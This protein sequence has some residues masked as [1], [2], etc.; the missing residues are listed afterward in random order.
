MTEPTSAHAQLI[1][2]PPVLYL[3]TLF[4]ALLIDAWQPWRWAQPMALRLLLTGTGL[5]LGAVLARWAFVTLHHHKTS[6]NPRQATQHIVQDGPF[7]W[8]RNPI[9]LAMT[10]LYLGASALLDS[11]WPIILLAPLLTVM[12][13]GVIRREEHYLDQC[14]GAAYRAYCERTRRWF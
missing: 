2:P 5:A 1:A 4:S 13:C 14:F 6:A 8:T 9:Y 3:S 7:R 12:Q 11:V 10:L